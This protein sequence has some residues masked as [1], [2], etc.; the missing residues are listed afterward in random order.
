MALGATRVPTRVTQQ[1]YRLCHK[2]NVIRFSL[3]TA[4][5]AFH[6]CPLAP[7][8][9]TPLQLDGSPHKCGAAFSSRRY[10]S[11]HLP[12]LRAT[13]TPLR[14]GH[15]RPLGTQQLQVDPPL[16]VPRANV[17]APR[18]NGSCPEV[19]RVLQ[20]TDDQN[21]ARRAPTSM[22]GNK[23]A[24]LSRISCIE[25][26]WRGGNGGPFVAAPGLRDLSQPQHTPNTTSIPSSILSQELRIYLHRPSSFDCWAAVHVYLFPRGHLDVYQHT[27][28]RVVARRQH[29]NKVAYIEGLCGS[30]HLVCQTFWIG[31]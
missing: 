13:P 14:L 12:R 19:D 5:A 17:R 25:G 8:A 24:A 4:V 15:F 1:L 26:R 23:L 11:H 9:P 16:G 2:H 3:P 18:L 30:G 10:L 7:V 22:G 28:Q 29:R 6:R 27:L 20:T 31:G 21:R